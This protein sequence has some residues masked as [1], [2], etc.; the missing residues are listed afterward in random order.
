MPQACTCIFSEFAPTMMGGLLPPDL[1]PSSLSSIVASSSGIV[2]LCREKGLKL[3]N[4]SLD[5]DLRKFDKL[6]RMRNNLCCGHIL[7]KQNS[8]RSPLSWFHPPPHQML[9]LSPLPQSWDDYDSFSF[10]LLRIVLNSFHFVNL[11]R[12]TFKPRLVLFPLLS[13]WSSSA[14]C[15][16]PHLFVC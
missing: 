7:D 4:G 5:S 9:C 13:I 3:E 8:P 2:R 14:S 12:S 15:G 6:Y 11:C 16:P 1:C 10:S